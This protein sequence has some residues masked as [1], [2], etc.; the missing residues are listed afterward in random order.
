MQ[1]MTGGRAVAAALKGEGIEHV[2]GI[3]GTHAS[4]LFDGLFDDPSI[5][6]PRSSRARRRGRAGS[7]RRA[8]G[9]AS[10]R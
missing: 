6:W 4:P 10:G 8:S 1:R 9:A 7:T 3:V 5:H 2:F